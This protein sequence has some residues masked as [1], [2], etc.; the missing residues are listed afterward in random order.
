MPNLFDIA[1]CKLTLNSKN[2]LKN[3]NL[4]LDDQKYIVTKLME[5]GCKK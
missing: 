5:N 1:S 2:E 4:L 3:I